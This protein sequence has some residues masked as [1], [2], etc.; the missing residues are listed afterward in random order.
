MLLGEMTMEEFAPCLDR[1]L[2]LPSGTVEEHGRHLPLSTDTMVVWAV[3]VEAGRRVPVL[4]AP[5]LHYG[6]CTSTSMHPGTIGIGFDTLRAL[7]RDIVRS[8]FEKGLRRFLI[9]SGHGGGAHLTALKEAGEELVRDLEGL[10]IASLS[11]YELVVE[12][13]REVVET[14]NDSHAGEIETSLMLYIREE[15]VKG[16][17]PEEYPQFPRPFLVRDKVRYWRGGVWGD[18]GKASKEK[19]ERIFMAMVDRVVDLIRRF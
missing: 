14:E 18:P 7:V 5:P 17:S 13:I 10:T 2:I 8:A 9:L 11:L 12:E 3:A 15:L 1:V 16:R 4:L 6:V 19:G